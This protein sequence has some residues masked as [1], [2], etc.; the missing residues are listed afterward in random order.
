VP[1]ELQ[2]ALQAEPALGKRFEALSFS[3]RKE[4]A[5]PIGEAKQAATRAARLEKAPARL[6]DQPEPRR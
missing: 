3:R 4:L 5:V 6:R 1:G 2:A